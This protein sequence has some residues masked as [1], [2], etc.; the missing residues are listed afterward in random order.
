MSD[1]D[2]SSSEDNISVSSQE[3]TNAD[4]KMDFSEDEEDLIT[5]LYNLL[6]QRWALIAGRIPGRSA[7]EIKKYCSRRYASD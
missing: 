6:G 7:E 2:R 5:R 3:E 1:I 4:S